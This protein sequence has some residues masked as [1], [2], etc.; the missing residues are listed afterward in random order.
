MCKCKKGEKH[1]KRMNK[2]F[3]F[4]EDDPQYVRLTGMT[5]TDI[6]KPANEE[7]KKDRKDLIW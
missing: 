1:G 4:F 7:R 6:N 2:V 3:F 5:I